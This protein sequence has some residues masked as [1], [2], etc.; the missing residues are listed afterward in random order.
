MAVVKY[1]WPPQTDT[2]ASAFADELVGVQ[3]VAGG[4][5]TNANFNFT[6]ELSEKQNRGFNIGTFSDPISLSDL[7]LSSVEESRNLAA[8]T[9]QVYPN[10]DLS[11]ITNFTLY[12]SLSKRISTSITKIINY[13][14]AAIE[15]LNYDLNF[16]TGLTADNIV[17]NQVLDETYLEIPINTLRN[18]FDIDFTVNATRNFELSEIEVS[19]LRNL[20]LL[21]KNYS[22]FVENVEYYV[23]FLTPV[24]NTD[25]VLKFY[26][27]GNPFN[28][29]SAT[30]QNIILRP[31]TFYTEKS[32][33]EFFDEVEQFLL[34]RLV[35]PIYSANFQV[36]QENDDGSYSIVQNVVTWPLD[37]KW[38]LDI[39]TNDFDKY[40]TSLNE[41]CEDLDSY[42]TD[43]ISR[44]FT[45]GAI[46]EFDT[47][48]R[49]VEKVLQIYGRSFDEVRKFVMSLANMTSVNYNTGNDI[50]SQLLKNLAE[51]LG[52]KTNISPI[53]NETLLES[54]FGTNQESNF[55][56]YS[57]SLTPNEIN[58]QFYKNLILNAAYLFKSKG[59]RRSIEILLRLV[60]A[61][62]ALIDFNEY[63]Y[64]ADERINLSQFDSQYLNISGGLYVSQIP[65][66][67]PTN[68]FT[69][70]GVQY[71][72]FTIQ[73]VI[74]ASTFSRT[75]YPMDSQGYP[76]SVPDSESYF[77][78]IGGG[79]FE[80]TPDHHMPE[81]VNETNQVFVGSNPNYQT[82]LLPFNY[83]QIYLDR[84]R[85]FPFM[86]L[87]YDLV[88]V[89]DNKKSWT[90]DEDGLRNTS[91][92][93]FTAYYRV[94][95]ERFVINVKNVD[96]FLNPAQG[97]AYDVWSMSR[98]YNYP[99]PNEGLDY[100]EPTYCNPYPN[101][102]YPNRGGIDWTEINPK[103]K[104]KTFFEFAQTF[105]KNM[106]NVRN[107]QFITDGK[108]GGYPTLQSIYWRYLES[109]Q[110]INIPNDNFTYKTMIE[111]VNGLGDYWIKL[112]GQLIPAT[113]LLTSGVRL[114]NS[115]FHRQKFV[116]RR[117]MGCKIVPVPCKP[118]SLVGQLFAYDCPIQE[119]VCPIYPWGSNPN[120]T[121]FAV[122]LNNLLLANNL[123]SPNCQ[124]DTLQSTWYV[125]LILN[126]VNLVHKEFFTGYGNT[127]PIASYP[128]A[129][130]W[131]VSLKDA[132]DDLQSDGLS[133]V[134]NNTN[135]TVTIY[136]GNCLPLSVTQDFKINVGIN[137][138]MLCN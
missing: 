126:G 113:T 48:D 68:I 26:V 96:V 93:G 108:T 118:C 1:K 53:S 81:N 107:R 35:K 19:P 44:F 100:I 24:E 39:R 116:W 76:S 37:G 46:K 45:T 78:Q 77:F 121:S 137:F 91:D 65:V 32:F 20:T 87:G 30:T 60:G 124:T 11:Q 6:T 42:K 23:T 51:T 128:S 25:N 56:G 104:Q 111:Y 112:V 38:N 123:L 13:F 57:R 129:N 5:L 71:T 109:N 99:I 86:N 89:I 62:E 134:I 61:P 40:I 130:T 55:P 105:W 3:L 16:V 41:I 21:Y 54:V 82:T 95:D 138:N 73:T 31:N 94:Y 133:Y 49:K 103:P 102:P 106:I 64:L 75:D 117:Q 17:Y 36:P 131:L 110:A 66:L 90:N 29:L 80:S 34:N 70:M 122:I 18:P 97:L 12:G 10:F 101:G 98:R 125:D 14:P 2:G 63:V 7:D 88:K 27:K 114:E 92:G 8:Q 69:I 22:I 132:L 127:N 50:P 58:Y 43:L 83:G 84:Y 47:S 52:W 115:I 74:S 119:V 9:L 67:D 85:R 72:G 136:N 15:S 33:T 28:G 120:V 59:T 4:G 79:W 135:Q